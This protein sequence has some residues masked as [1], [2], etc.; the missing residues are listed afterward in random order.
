MFF[1]FN[2]KEIESQRT[3]LRLRDGPR[4]FSLEENPRLITL[5]KILLSGPH[6]PEMFCI[7]QPLHQYSKR[8]GKL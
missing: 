5:C 2:P 8:T 7:A 6:A 4:F 1:P 3:R